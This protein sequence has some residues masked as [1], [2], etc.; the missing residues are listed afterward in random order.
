MGSSVHAEHLGT[1]PVPVEPARPAD[2]GAT[3]P[4]AQ[5][6]VPD[7]P[8]WPGPGPLCSNRRYDIVHLHE[9][10]LPVACSAALFATST[11]AGATFHMTAASRR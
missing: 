5:P 7:R 4:P 6:R 9:P 10:M 2:G 11:P 8:R 3:H 1:D